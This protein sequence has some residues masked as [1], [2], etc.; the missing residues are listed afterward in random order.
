[1]YERFILNRSG[2]QAVAIQGEEI[3]KDSNRDTS[4]ETEVEWEK[5]RIF[6]IDPVWARQRE[7][8]EWDENKRRIII[9]PY[10]IGFEF[11]KLWKGGSNHYDVDDADNIEQVLDIIRDKAP[12]LH[13]IY[14]QLKSYK[15]PP[16][17]VEYIQYV[18]E[19]R[20]H[21][22]GRRSLVA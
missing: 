8:E 12:R 16:E 6:E 2:Q 19:K 17:V 15:A 9:S 20:S 21:G 14:K 3:A 1:M 13:D 18:M 7:K 5:A 22:S 11:G 4:V 10:S